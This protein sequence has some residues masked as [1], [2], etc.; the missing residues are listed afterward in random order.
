MA[1]RPVALLPVGNLTFP[2][3]SLGFHD[4]QVPHGPALGSECFNMGTGWPIDRPLTVTAQ[5]SVTACSSADLDSQ[6]SE[7]VP[8][9][10]R[11]AGCVKDS[12]MSAL[13]AGLL[14]SEKKVHSPPLFSH[15]V[16]D[17]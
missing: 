7:I 2:G 9:T 8:C 16:G 12:H 14:R 6:S 1:K 3:S 4:N 13:F 10:P 17:A 11:G 15:V 5:S